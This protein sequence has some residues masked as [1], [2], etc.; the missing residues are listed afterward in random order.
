M[1]ATATAADVLA[2]R[3]PADKEGNK[4]RL[5]DAGWGKV[6]AHA[7]AKE[8]ER[9]ADWKP[10][11]L[12]FDFDAD[13]PAPDWI[14]HRLMERGTVVV[15]SGDTGAAKSIVTSSIL[16][17]ALTG[18]EWL[19][20]AT[21]VERAMVVDEENPSRLVRARLRAL[22]TS[23]D[24]RDRLRYFNREGVALGDD[25]RSD[26]WMRA[27]LAEFRPDLLIIDT[28]MAACDLEDTNSNS[29]AVRMMKGLRALARDFGCAILL[30]HHERKRSREHPASSGQAMM[31]AR[32][33]AGQADAHMT[34][35]VESDL[36]E[37]DAETEGH[38]TLRRSFRW[39]PAEKDRDG[40]SNIARRVAVESEKDAAGR[41]LWMKV[42]DEGPIVDEGAQDTAEAAMLGL[43]RDAGG[44]GSV[45]RRELAA[46]AGEKNAGEPSG[47]FKRALA[48]LIDAGKVETVGRRYKATATG[49]EAPGLAVI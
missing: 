45:A 33:W 19:G 28:L 35:T 44:D 30:L 2:G 39:R 13:P 46:A 34:L 8:F 9:A 6:D 17:A 5:I 42:T 21:H 20:H 43:L 29:E 25:G 1:S 48:D 36:T 38:R 23:N 14:V 47:T 26:H 22:G 41:L 49:L 37:E 12:A 27:Q 11:P 4:A 7:A 3:D 16:P 32:Q 40:R 10:Q 18:A 15:L 31:G 24:L